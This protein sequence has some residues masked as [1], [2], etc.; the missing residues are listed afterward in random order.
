MQFS[1]LFFDHP[2]ISGSVRA[3]FYGGLLILCLVDYPSPLH[4]PKILHGVSPLFYTPSRILRLLGSP[5]QRPALLRIV[6]LLTIGVWIAAT[7]GLL[8]PLTGVLTFLGFAFLHAAN[9]GALGAN[10]STHSALYAL[11][12]LCFSVSNDAFSLDAWLSERMP[13]PRLVAPGSVLESGFARELL[14]ISFVYVMFAGGVAKLRNGGKAWFT[15]KMLRFYMDESVAFARS[16]WVSK[17]LRSR[18]HLCQ[19]LAGLT[20][21][22]EMSGV[23]SLVFPRLTPYVVLG[24]IGLHVGILLVMAPAYWVQMWCYMLLIDWGSLLGIG[25]ATPWVPAATDRGAMTTLTAFT[26]LYCLTLLIVLL[27]RYEEWPFT[28]VPMYSNGTPPADRRLP[29]RAELQSKAVAAQRGDLTAWHCPWVPAEV[30][31]EIQIVP[32]GGGSPRPLIELLAEQ[33][34]TPVRWSQWSKV[35]RRVAIDDI[36]A[37]PAG[38]PGAT[39]PDYPAAMFLGQLAALLRER[40]PSAGDYQRLDMVVHT[41]EGPLVIGSARLANVATYACQPRTADFT[42]S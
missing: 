17:Q 31:E 35:V 19:A 42:P 30:G 6:R 18:P 21:V 27:R 34:A 2:P 25:G 28:S 16:P 38:Q 22:I 13:W 15:G 12:A 37:K 10:H 9:A 1:A 32:A 11:F 3:V 36:A 26:G 4:A 41:A 8:Q 24:W 14:L 20:V 23:L 33:G 40:L 39:G 29:A 7:L 5:W